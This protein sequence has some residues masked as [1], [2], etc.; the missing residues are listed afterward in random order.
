MAAPSPL[1]RGRPTRALVGDQP[2]HSSGDQP[3]NWQAPSPELVRPPVLFFLERLFFRFL[4][5]RVAC[6]RQLTE[7]VVQPALN[8]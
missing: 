8:F 3:E 7:A 2:E 1:P 5:S 6:P 4:P